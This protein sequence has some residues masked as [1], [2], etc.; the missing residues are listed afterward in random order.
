MTVADPKKPWAVILLALEGSTPNPQV[1]A[2]FRTLFSYSGGIMAPL[3]GHRSFTLA[4]FWRDVSLG[5]ID[6][7][8]SEVF[9]WYTCGWSV[10][11]S[12]RMPAFPGM[13]EGI[14][15]GDWAAHARFILQLNNQSLSLA[16][17]RGVL[18]VWNF[19]TNGGSQGADVVYGLNGVGG[20]LAWAERGWRWCESCSALVGGQVAGLA[21]PAAGQHQLGPTRDYFVPTQPSLAQ[22]AAFLAC[23]KCGGLFGGAVGQGVCAAGGPHQAGST[24]YRVMAGWG[25]CLGQ[26][27]WN[28]CRNCSL[29]LFRDRA[30]FEKLVCPVGAQPHDPLT[31]SLA[32]LSFPFVEYGYNRTFLTHEMGHAYGF[33]HGRDTT[34]QSQQL[35]NDCFPGA[36]GDRFDI[37]SAMNVDCFDPA[38]SDP[39]S[40]LG[41]AGPGL[42]IHHLLAADFVE[43]SAILDVPENS[44]QT[45]SL[46][47][48]LR[49]HLAGYAAARLGKLVIEF[50]QRS[51]QDSSGNLV[52]VGWDRN[53]S[54]GAGAGAVLVYD[55]QAASPAILTSTA[56]RPYLGAGDRYESRTGMGDVS[57]SV[58]SIDSAGPTA[59]VKVERHP[60]HENRWQRWLVLPCAYPDVATN[61]KSTTELRDLFNQ[62]VE[63]FWE[64][65]GWDAFHV[66]GGFVV[67]AQGDKGDAWIPLTTPSTVEAGL[68]SL[69]RVQ[70]AVQV[71]LG[72]NNPV[73]RP[74][75]PVTPLYLDWRWF[76]GIIV[77]H[78]ARIGAGYIGE[79]GFWTGN[80]PSTLPDCPNTT[81]TGSAGGLAS[82]KVIEL[83]SD[84]LSQAAIAQA[85]GN[86][87]GLPRGGQDRFDLMCDLQGTHRYLAPD[88]N[89]PIKASW[90]FCGPCLSTDSL[91]RLDWLDSSRVFVAKV[92]Q[93]RQWTSGSITLAPTLHK[94]YEGYRRAEMGPYALECRIAESW[95]GG[96]S[97][98]AAVLL[99]EAGVVTRI[100]KKGDG[101]SWGGSLYRLGGGGSFA[102]TALS[103]FGAT[104]WYEVVEPDPIVAGGGTLHGGGT[105]LFTYDG[106]ILRIPPGDPYEHVIANL[107]NE[108]G[109]ITKRIE[110]RREK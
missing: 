36:Y 60:V 77:I 110:E 26:D 98:P 92:A 90:G 53:L 14:G 78:N 105:I 109:N 104:I 45:I 64:Q 47:P 18:S 6:V 20:D 59:V 91:K 83:G 86:S 51:Q 49:R 32:E 55:L 66:A 29:V 38:P 50:R 42:S 87:L 63:P 33:I 31:G 25:S 44:S 40:Q 56:G 97:E 48:V 79:T 76:T 17:Y 1:I 81:T 13:S 5:H 2:D 46:R 4:D 16:K 58:V 21:C 84:S 61:P 43:S 95:D 65:L 106:R 27:K 62:G 28:Q 94:E 96:M 23:L 71:A 30:D 3:Q 8:S 54:I 85:I 75:G 9:G 39:D 19:P 82:Y 74:S 10:L 73:S 69:R 67:S 88:D 100:L 41:T 101:H 99:Y 11:K 68:T 35:D 15:R 57:I 70:D 24:A 22:S 89:G 12:R 80:T 103:P 37:M 108:L 52:P 72:L 34:P 7:S 93:G 102:V 107:L